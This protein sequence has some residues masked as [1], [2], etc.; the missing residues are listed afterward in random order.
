MLYSLYIAFTRYDLLSAPRWVGLNNFRLLFQDPEFQQAV[1]I[2]LKFTAISVPL[3]LVCSL[4]LALLLNHQMRGLGVYRTLFY[5]PSL[6]GGSA[7]IAILWLTIF[8]QPGLV[9]D[10]LSVFHIHPSSFV[11]NP[12]T[13]MYTIVVL[14]LWAFGATMVIFLAG[15]RN[16]PREYYEA[17]SIDGAGRWYSFWK[18]TLPLLTP[19]IFFNFIL[20]TVMTS[21]TFTSAYIIGGGSGGPAG[22]LLFYTVYIYDAGFANFKMGYASAMA[23]LMLAALG[24]FTAICF[25]TARYW[26]HYGD[27]R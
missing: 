13:A 19:L 21:Q 18:I 15:L 26:V 23:W 24:V 22:S 14:N 5:L 17:A 12:A 8:G 2:T 1:N 10:V 9:I 4:G 6:L 27:E 16:I 3:V 25:A 11:G 7:S 20:T